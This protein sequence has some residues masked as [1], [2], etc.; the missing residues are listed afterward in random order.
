M[1]NEGYVVLL[2][3]SSHHKLEVKVLLILLFCF[4]I[5]LLLLFLHIRFLCSFVFLGLKLEGYIVLLLIC[6]H[7]KLEDSSS[8]FFDCLCYFFFLN[9][10]FLCSFMFLSWWASLIDCQ[11]VKAIFPYAGAVLQKY[12]W[13]D[14]IFAFAR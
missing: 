5:L 12:L 4:F 8:N 2:L 13:K 9:L 10:R 6:G 1:K 11:R 7:H 3:I 14:V